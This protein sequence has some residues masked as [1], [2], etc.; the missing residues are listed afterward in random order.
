MGFHSFIQSNLFRRF[1]SHPTS[2]VRSLPELHHNRINVGVW[3]YESMSTYDVQSTEGRLQT[4]YIHANIK[5]VAYTGPRWQKSAV[6]QEMFGFLAIFTSTWRRCLVDHAHAFSDREE[7]GFMLLNRVDICRNRH[8]F[9][10][11]KKGLISAQFA[12]WWRPFR[13]PTVYI[14]VYTMRDTL[15]RFSSAKAPQ[16]TAGSPEVRMGPILDSTF[17][18]YLFYLFFFRCFFFFIP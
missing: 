6:C 9:L 14:W 7:N 10:C 12:D 8:V 2:V 18:F 17:F 4:I 1:S 11:V 5:F 15:H 13:R 16:K 3:I